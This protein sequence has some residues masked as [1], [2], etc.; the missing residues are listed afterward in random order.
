LWRNIQDGEKPISETQIDDY[1]LAWNAETGEI[2]FYPSTS[3]LRGFKHS[4]R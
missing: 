1:A 4:R 3:S 2:S